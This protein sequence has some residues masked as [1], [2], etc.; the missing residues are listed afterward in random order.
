VGD[1]DLSTGHSI[2][3]ALLAHTDCTS[4]K[5]FC[6]SYHHYY[7][8]R[9]ITRIMKISVLLW[10]TWTAVS[11]ALAP[12]QQPF[13]A[14]SSTMMKPPCQRGR[15][16]SCVP[17]LYLSQQSEEESS[18]TSQSSKKPFDEK[19]RS[20]LV[21]EAIAPWRTV[22]LFFYGTLGAGALVGGLITL[23][24]TLAALQ[25]LRPDLDLTEQVCHERDSI[26]SIYDHVCDGRSIRL[27]QK[28]LP[29]LSCTH[30]CIY[31]RS[32]KTWQ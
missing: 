8:V 19:L 25:G 1:T 16:T 30:F 4:K 12:P 10:L 18:A 22:R 3:T 7:T 31:L 32:T 21:S 23:T 28:L 13:W 15:M 11:S 26:Y 20:K 5:S 6:R 2:T 29:N 9:R 17:P 14:S 24:G 27:T